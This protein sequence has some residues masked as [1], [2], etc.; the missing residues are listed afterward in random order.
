MC[1]SVAEAGGGIAVFA[2][3]TDMIDESM[4]RLLGYASR[5][6]PMR[7]KAQE[8]HVTLKAQDL[9]IFI[10][11]SRSPMKLSCEYFNDVNYRTCSVGL[12][13]LAHFQPTFFFIV[14]SP[15]EERKR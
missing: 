15:T 8:C 12:S 6:P 3:E 10:K 13:Y 9:H 11:P 7:V 14:K 5:K 4:T 1:T 2:Q